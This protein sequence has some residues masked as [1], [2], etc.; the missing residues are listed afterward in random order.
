LC[1]VSITASNWCINHTFATRAATAPRER[2]AEC[3]RAARLQT[4]PRTVA[5]SASASARARGSG[6]PG[7]A[8]AIAVAVVV[9]VADARQSARECEQPWNLER[10]G[11]MA[12]RWLI[13]GVV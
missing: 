13:S 3:R 9:A 11:E 7:G 2:L 4:P 8:V 10:D 12:R 5:A 1:C 6:T